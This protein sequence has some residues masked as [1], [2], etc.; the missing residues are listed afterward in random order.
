MKQ[1]SCYFAAIIATFA[2]AC[3]GNVDFWVPSDAAVTDTNVSDVRQDTDFD[4][5]D[6][7]S[8]I[9]FDT[10]PDGPDDSQIVDV[11]LDGGGMDVD[12]DVEVGP[13]TP[14]EGGSELCPNA[15]SEMAYRN[16]SGH[17]YCIDK[18][19]VTTRQYGRWLSRSPSVDTQVQSCSWNKS[20]APTCSFTP[21]TKP[22]LPVA[23]VDW[24]DATAF[25]ASRGKRL[26]QRVKLGENFVDEFIDACKNGTPEGTLDCKGSGEAL[27]SAVAV[28]SKPKCTNANG[29]VDLLGNVEEWTDRCTGAGP[30]RKCEVSGGSYLTHSDDYHC[31]SIKAPLS[32]RTSRAQTGFRC[33]ADPLPTP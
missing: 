16:V 21:D 27:T 32:I 33:C 22:R 1:P 14:L 3:G 8:D 20:F 7:L 13:D 15:G 12:H 31:S 5:G 26:C 19:E 4:A 18:T 17:A 30:A 6:A 29:V 11:F 23:C 24:C 28:G 2:V 9:A 10:I 25:C